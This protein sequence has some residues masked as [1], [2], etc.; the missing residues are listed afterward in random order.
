MYCLSGLQ[1]DSFTSSI[2]TLRTVLPFL[3][4]THPDLEKTSMK[5]NKYLTFRF[6][7]ANDPIS[8]KSVAQILYLNVA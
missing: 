6:L 2:K 4:L 5:H 8:A 1:L 7:E 3:C